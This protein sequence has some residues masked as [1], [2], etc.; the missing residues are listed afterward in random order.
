MSQRLA[1]VV[2]RLGAIPDSSI[3]ELVKWGLPAVGPNG[4][5]FDTADE[6]C[7]ALEE[8]SE[9]EDQVLVRVTDPD[10]VKH[11]LRTKTKGRLHLV[12]EE[13]QDTFD[14]EF[15]K[16]QAAGFPDEYIMQWSADVDTDL[17]TN[18][19]SYLQDGGN[20]VYFLRVQDLYFGDAR[21]FIICTP[22]P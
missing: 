14:W 17:L 4:P 10:A 16:K 2:A 22:R 3:R 21:V 7:A 5:S 11:Y 19:E 8:A 1:E 15:G 20:K 9:S 18:G 6:A 12:S 13:M